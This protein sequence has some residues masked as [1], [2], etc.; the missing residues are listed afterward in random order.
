MASENI[1]SESN[2]DINYQDNNIDRDFVNEALDR[3]RQIILDEFSHRFAP[4]AKKLPVRDTFRFKSEGLNVQFQFNL[5]RIDKLAEI[6]SSLEFGS[7]EKV[8]TIISEESK[9][10]KDRNKI[11]K[12]ADTHGWDT[13]KEYDT[14]PLADDS[15]DANKLRTAINR[16]RYARKFKPYVSS[17]QGSRS[18]VS[19]GSTG[20]RFPSKFQLFPEPQVRFGASVQGAQIRYPWKNQQY[21][22]ATSFFLPHQNLAKSHHLSSGA[23]GSKPLKY[24]NTDIRE[25][26]IYNYD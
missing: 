26:N 6:E 9:L 7:L 20:Q 15:E 8:K 21:T 18:S 1:S 11:L 16:A 3:Q 25:Q 12:I 14:D 23:K 22:T 19:A 2:R 4:S 24:K 17:T 5:D 10:L 13:V